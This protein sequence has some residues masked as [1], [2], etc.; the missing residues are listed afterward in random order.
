[1][2]ALHGQCR[3]ARLADPR[4]AGS[5]LTDGPLRLLGL[6]DRNPI[7]RERFRRAKACRPEDKVTRSS[8]GD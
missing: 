8:C 7:K 5:T 6:G 4:P 1:V 3:N 2:A